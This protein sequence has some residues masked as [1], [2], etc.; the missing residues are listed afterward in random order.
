MTRKQAIEELKRT[1]KLNTKMLK[2][3]NIGFDTFLRFAQIK[4]KNQSYEIIKQLIIK[5][6][7]VNN[8]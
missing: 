4:D 2:P 5:L 6:E 1:K 7:T 3:L 8:D